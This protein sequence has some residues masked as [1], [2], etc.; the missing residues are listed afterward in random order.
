MTDLEFQKFLKLRN[1]LSI[2]GIG[3]IRIVKLLQNFNSLDNI[4]SASKLEIEK[5]A[6]INSN[7]A[8]RILG[9][10]NRLDS[11]SRSLEKEILK[12]EKMGGQI[13]TYWD[14]VYPEILRNIYLPP[15]I[16]YVLGDFQKSDKH[17]VSVVGTRKPTDYGKVVTAKFTKELAKQNITIVSGLARGIDSIAHRSAIKAGGRTIAVIGSGLDVVYPPENKALFNDI[18][19]NGVVISEFELGTKPD[20]QNFPKRNRIISGISLGTLVIESR[21]N[22]GAMQTANYAMDQNREVFA[23]PGN[24]S[25]PES[26]GTNTLIQRNEAKLV[27]EPNDILIELNLKIQPEVGR[28]IPKPKLD[29]TLFEEKI[30]DNLTTSPKHIDIIANDTLLS[31]SECLVNL[32]SLEFKSVI[33]QLPGKMFKLI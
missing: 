22:G 18:A 23:I 3:P 21:K 10:K 13:I 2:D 30:L 28:N 17:S 16:L 27:V 4:Y 15:L 33:Q 5:I 32:L 7:L 14:E 11:L 29:L 26:E 25:I 8:S 24:L 19:K 6:S 12:L 1:L 9:S 31:T 20:A